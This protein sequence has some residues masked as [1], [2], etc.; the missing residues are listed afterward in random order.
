M[1]SDSDIEKCKKLK[2]VG[3][4]LIVTGVVFIVAGFVAIPFTG[5]ISVAAV[6]PGII[7]AVLGLGKIGEADDIIKKSQQKEQPASNDETKAQ[8]FS[9]DISRTHSN[10]VVPAE[11]NKP[12]CLNFF[13]KKKNAEETKTPADH[14]VDDAALKPGR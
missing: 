8:F 11:N 5:A 7:V 13:S 4:T 10:K 3:V 9:F 6:L 12:S 1:D 2:I 14:N